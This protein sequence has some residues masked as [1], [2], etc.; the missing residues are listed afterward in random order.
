[1]NIVYTNMLGYF[2]ARDFFS[3]DMSICTHD[4]STES[5]RGGGDPLFKQDVITSPINRPVL[6]PCLRILHYKLVSLKDEGGYKLL[7]PA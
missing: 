5:N 4:T 3:L 1:M 7:N 6:D 2:I